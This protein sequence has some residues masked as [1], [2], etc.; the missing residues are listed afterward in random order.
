MATGNLASVVVAVDGSEESMN[1][2]QWALDNLR[3]R[4]DGELVV[5]HVQPPPN[6]AAGLN[7]APIPFGGPSGGEDGGGGR[8]PQG[9]NLRDCG[10]PQGRSARHGLPCHWAAKEGVLGQCEQ[11]LYQPCGLP[12]CCDQGDMIF[13][14]PSILWC[15]S[16]QGF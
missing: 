6:I 2:L 16:I 12:C 10:Q 8:G 3:L 9:E 13:H 11:L 1:A 15:T 7:P 14:Q 5:L 4:P